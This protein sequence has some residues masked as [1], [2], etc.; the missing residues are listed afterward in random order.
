MKDIIYGTLTGLLLS[1]A[2]ITYSQIDSG[3]RAVEVLL[4]PPSH[5][6][7]MPGD[8]L[9]RIAQEHF[10]TDDPRVIVGRLMEINGVGDKIYPGMKL[11]LT[12]G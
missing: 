12:E 4:P 3:Y 6:W 10:P 11:R 8:S 7:V 9:W 5:V 1:L 2:I